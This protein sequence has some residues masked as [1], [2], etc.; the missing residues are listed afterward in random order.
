MANDRWTPVDGPSKVDKYEWKSPSDNTQHEEQTVA[1]GDLMIK[2]KDLA[3]VPT[4]AP[5]R[6]GI[7]WGQDAWNYTNAPDQ[8]WY[9]FGMIED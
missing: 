9:V 4:N 2:P 1:P 7:Q 6:S 5:K 8:S 3:L